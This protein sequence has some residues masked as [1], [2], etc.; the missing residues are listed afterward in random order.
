[1]LRNSD[2]KI[3]VCQS[4]IRRANCYHKI[5]NTSAANMP[6]NLTFLTKMSISEQKI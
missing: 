4:E 3:F 6:G 2:K 5:C 1:M